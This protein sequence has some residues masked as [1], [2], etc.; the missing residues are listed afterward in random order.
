MHGIAPALCRLAGRVTS[1][2][3]PSKSPATRG[4]A[5]HAI[6]T[7]G[8]AALAS[9]PP[10][11]TPDASRTGARHLPLCWRAF[12]HSLSCPT[13]WARPARKAPLLACGALSKQGGPRPQ[14]SRT[15]PS[16]AALPP[17]RAAAARRH[18]AHNARHTPPRTNCT[19]DV[20]LRLAAGASGLAQFVP[21]GSIPSRSRPCSRPVAPPPFSP[22][23]VKLP[24]PSEDRLRRHSPPLLTQA[25]WPAPHQPAGRHLAFDGQ[26]AGGRVGRAKCVG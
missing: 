15:R 7:P 4:P 23:P 17:K 10:T 2:P 14:A 9:F 24:D 21:S 25:L 12:A 11:P 5:A 26:P 16:L 18:G 6:G 1:Q 3:R 8:G 13:R 19:S 20:P 22:P